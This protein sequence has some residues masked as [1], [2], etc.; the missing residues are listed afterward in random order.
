[1][2]SLA[3]AGVLFD[4][5]VKFVWPLFLILTVVAGLFIAGAL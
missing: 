1:M 5:W 3:I 4:K 2:A